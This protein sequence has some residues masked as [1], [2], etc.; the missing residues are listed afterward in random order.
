M[1][2]T[3]SAATKRSYQSSVPT[4]HT[5]TM[6][7]VWPAMVGESETYSNLKD[8]MRC[9][10][11]TDFANIARSRPPNPG[12]RILVVRLPPSIKLLSQHCPWKLE[13]THTKIKELLR[14]AG[15]VGAEHGL[16]SC[17][18]SARYH[19]CSF[20]GSDHISE[21]RYTSAFF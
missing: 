7:K 15:P 11:T 5:M 6:D 18:R 2:S 9:H 3:A 8:R 20:T 21:R 13:T 14:D 1:L 4:H 12:R 19:R 17:A 16:C 10:L